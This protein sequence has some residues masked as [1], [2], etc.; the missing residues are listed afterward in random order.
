LG[1]AWSHLPTGDLG[2]NLKGAIACFEAALHVYT[3]QGFPQGWA[4]VQSNLGDTWNSLPTGDKEANVAK[5]IACFEAALRVFTEQEFPHEWAIVQKRLD[6][7]Q[8]Y[9]TMVGEDLCKGH[10]QPGGS[11]V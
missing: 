9:L 5:A 3:E 4:R 8:A 1:N 7:S 2:A 11:E 10:R 6:N